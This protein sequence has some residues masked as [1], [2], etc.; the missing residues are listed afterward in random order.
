[1]QIFLATHLSVHSGTIYIYI[2]IYWLIF[3]HW[4][5]LKPRL[6][7]DMRYECHKQTVGKLGDKNGL[8]PKY[9]WEALF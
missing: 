3:V 4:T 7:N 8:D 9:E 1:M 2:Y 5:A 6:E